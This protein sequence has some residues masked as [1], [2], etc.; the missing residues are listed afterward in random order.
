M[1]TKKYFLS[2]VTL[3]ILSLSLVFAAHTITTSTG[4]TEYSVNESIQNIYNITVSNTDAGQDANITKVSIRIPGNFAFTTGSNGTNVSDSAFTSTSTVLSWTNSS[5]TYIINGSST[6]HVWFNATAT[7][8]SYNL[9]VTTQNTTGQYSTNISVEVNDTTNPTA[10][11]GTDI[12]NNYNSSSTN[13]TFDIKG[14]DAYSIEALQIWGNWSG[15]WA[16][17]Y[18]NASIVND[19]FLNISVNIPEGVYVWGV[20]VNDSTNNGDWTTNRTLIVDTTAPTVSAACSPSSANVDATIT[21]TCAGTETL[22]GIN[23]SLITANSTPST[24]TVGTYYYFCNITD[25]AGNSADDNI[26]YTVTTDNTGDDSTSSTTP[27]FFWTKG[28][29]TVT[30][31]QFNNSYSKELWAKQRLKVTVESEDHYIGVIELTTTTATI[32]VTSDPQ[33]AILVVGDERR[34]EVTDD[35]YYDIFVRLNSIENNRAN[36]TTQFIHELITP[37]TT[38][39]EDNLQ[40]AGETIAG[41]EQGTGDDDKKSNIIWWILGIVVIIIIFVIVGV[42]YAN[43][44]KYPSIK[45]K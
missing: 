40:D 2:I 36:I 15:A 20:F 5:A 34:F 12:I 41:E 25:Y 35:E 10:S 27:A 39:T 31:E 1:E 3:L 42:L 32:N 14:S 38:E 9:I 33:Q 26:T 23:P 44:K 45:L 19:T 11:F 6:N 8:G 13:I 30:G 16:L 28:T 37:E 29:Q 7:P 24:S 17:N 21:C 43:R 22:S 18:S 4:G